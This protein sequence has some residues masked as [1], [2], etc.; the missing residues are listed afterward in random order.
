MNSPFRQW[1]AASFRRF[2]QSKQEVGRRAG[3]SWE[4]IFSHCRPARETTA[5][6]RALHTSLNNP[7]SSCS[8]GMRL[9][10]NRPLRKARA[11]EL[12]AP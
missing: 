2:A 4:S 1:L 11:W 9:G 12:R 6:L 8:A 3:Q 7:G 10:S 5:P